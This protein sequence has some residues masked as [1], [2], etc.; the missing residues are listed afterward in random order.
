MLAAPLAVFA[1]PLADIGGCLQNLWG[2]L[3]LFLDGISKFSNLG[4][5]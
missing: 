2:G 5:R 1:E 3:D 4:L